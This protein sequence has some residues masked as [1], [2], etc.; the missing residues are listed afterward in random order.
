MGVLK[1]ER[2]MLALGP[3]ATLKGDCA[4]KQ[5][6]WLQKW[7]GI[8][9]LFKVECFLS[10]QCERQSTPRFPRQKEITRGLLHSPPC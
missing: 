3:N 6:D 2:A 8:P 5:P 4:A 7:L 9:A 10:F 1:E